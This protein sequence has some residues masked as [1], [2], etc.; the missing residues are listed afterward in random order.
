MT[1]HNLY[2]YVLFSFSLNEKC[3]TAIMLLKLGFF[4]PFSFFFGVPTIWETPQKL[5]P[6][7]TGTIE[8]KISLFTSHS[9]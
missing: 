2:I 6:V 4:S 7:F 5:R 3:H 1:K 8:N 9:Y